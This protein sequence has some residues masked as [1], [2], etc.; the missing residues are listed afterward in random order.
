[1]ARFFRD[2]IYLG[3]LAALAA[4]FVVALVLAMSRGGSSA[5]ASVAAP[6]P[7][8]VA[9][10]TEA[11]PAPT[12]IAVRTPQLYEVL[13]DA[14]RVLDLAA[15]Q[16]AL[17]AYHQRFGSY[18]STEGA[19]QSV[20]GANGDAG[21]ALS[22]VNGKTLIQRRQRRLSVH[23]GRQHVHA[24]DAPANRRLAR[25]LRRRRAARAR[26]PAGLLP[27]AKGEALIMDNRTRNTALALAPAVA[28]GVIALAATSMLHSFMLA[29]PLDVV[30]IAAV[31]A[32]TWRA[33]VALESARADV[34]IAAVTPV[35]M[36]RISADRRRPTFDRETGLL[37]GLVL[38]APCRR[39]DR[40]RPAIRPEVHDATRRPGRRRCT[41]RHRPR[42]PQLSA[43]HRPRR[44]HRFNHV[45]TP[46][47]HDA[48][49]RGDRRR[50]PARVVTGRANRRRR[51]PDRCRY[52]R[53]LARRDRMDHERTTRH[54]Y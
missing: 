31:V 5:S 52:A 37:A 33:A 3:G 51:M 53:R 28:G 49:C 15:L 42:H 12:P 22:A 9:T 50:A 54:W 44:Q 32:I 21:C 25:R 24:R 4:V 35:V 43:R 23:V 2:P 36:Q 47:E 16:D 34:A 17:A 1:M 48:R 41:R 39:G 30:V 10:A 8:A 20:C 19:A 6:N 45:R 13:L 7:T 38:P 14:R 18:P 11:A 26:R 29:L 40:A 46:T 27:G